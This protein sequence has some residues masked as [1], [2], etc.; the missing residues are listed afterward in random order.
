MF[1]WRT[2]KTASRCTYTWRSAKT[3][4][5]VASYRVHETVAIFHRH[6]AEPFAQPKPR[7]AS[8]DEASRL[9]DA[10]SFQDLI[11]LRDELMRRGLI[12]EPT[13]SQLRHENLT[14]YMVLLQTVATQ[15]VGVYFIADVLTTVLGRNEPNMPD[16]D[17]CARDDMVRDFVAEMEKLPPMPFILRMDVFAETVREKMYDDRYDIASQLGMVEVVA[18]AFASFHQLPMTIEGDVSDVATLERFRLN[19]LDKLGELLRH[20]ETTAVPPT[21]AECDTVRDEDD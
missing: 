12:D 11:T 19:I 10:L 2:A 18:R 15:S 7:L 9:M 14:E 3:Q 8:M 17:K 16:E 21:N 1:P 4:P 20:D 13:D 5:V 6:C